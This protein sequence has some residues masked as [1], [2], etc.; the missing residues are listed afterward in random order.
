AAA[1]PQGKALEL[2]VK[3]KHG[4]YTYALL[5]GLAGAAAP[6]QAEI[7]VDALASYLS[8]RVPE[9]SLQVGGYA[10]QPMRSA[11]RD[12]F[13]LVRRVKGP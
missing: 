8:R 7:E 10:Q 11:Y 5:E 3:Q 12:S 4:V 13:P 2:G 6:G 1:S 9:L